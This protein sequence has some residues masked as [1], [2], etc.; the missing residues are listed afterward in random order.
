MDPTAAAPNTSSAAGYAAAGRR[1]SALAGM[2]AL[3]L[4]SAATLRGA[5]DRQPARAQDTGETAARVLVLLDGAERVRPPDYGYTGD[6]V[7]R[8]QQTGYGVVARDPR[9]LPGGGLR[10]EDF[11][12]AVIAFP[13]TLP[14]NVLG[15]VERAARQRTLPVLVA[16]PAYVEPLALGRIWDPAN[17]N[18]TV[19]G[20]TVEIDAR[21]A[22]I[23]GGLVGPVVLAGGPGL[24][25][26]PYAHTLYRT[27]ILPEG[28]VL[29]W[30]ADEAGERRAVWSLGPDGT[31]MYLGVW[32]SADG[33][34]H[35][36]AYW[37][38]FDGSVRALI[39]AGR[40]Q[41]PPATPTPTVPPPALALTP[42]PPRRMLPRTGAGQWDHRPA[43]REA[44][45]RLLNLARR[46]C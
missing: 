41:P 27:P 23:A 17:P 3:G 8:L 22:A 28:T 10:L 20:T 29:G 32:W 37:R 4:G 13:A 16:A 7:P 5:P 45:G 19:Y 6:W 42:P 25:V 38:L 18:R 24:E 34:N 21:A 31:R 11:A 2:L 26:V 46:G 15:E 44:V 1:R 9:G 36:A 12:L 35:N 30:I 14:A 33:R 43:R 40:G 39:A